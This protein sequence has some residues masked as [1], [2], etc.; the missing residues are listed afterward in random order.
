MDLVSCHTDIPF[1]TEHRAIT[2]CQHLGIYESAL[3]FKIQRIRRNAVKHCL[4]QMTWA[5]K[6]LR[7]NDCDLYKTYV[8]EH[9]T[10]QH[11]HKDTPTPVY[12]PTERRLVI[13]N[14]VRSISMGYKR[15]W[16]YT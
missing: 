7:C 4:L 14:K 13:M 11:R 8:H 1:N 9:L 16:G 12:P 3:E 15:E 10:V 2:Y 6:S 5:L